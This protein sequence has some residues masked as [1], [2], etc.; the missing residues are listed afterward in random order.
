MWAWAM[1]TVA[2][3]NRSIDN[4]PTGSN[5]SPWVCRWDTVEINFL[6]WSTHADEGYYRWSDRAWAVSSHYQLLLV[7]DSV[8]C[9]FH[10]IVVP[11]AACKTCA[12]KNSKNGKEAPLV[13]KTPLFHTPH[14]NGKSNLQIDNGCIKNALHKGADMYH[15]SEMVPVLRQTSIYKMQDVDVPVDV[16]EQ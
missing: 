13:S 12:S 7:L 4:V 2:L 8:Q 6:G 9:C 15:R 11:S 3:K 16:R 14:N 5:F 1:S 10:P